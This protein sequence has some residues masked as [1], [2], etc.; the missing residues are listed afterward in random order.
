MRWKKLGKIFNPLEH[1]LADN[2]KEFAQSP[3]VL[4]LDTCYRVYFST[5]AIDESGKYISYV[6]FAEF[7]KSFSKVLKVSDKTIITRGELGTFDEHGIFP[8]N[9]LRDGD[10][11]LGYTSGWFRRESVLVDS[12]IGLTISCDNGLTFERVGIGPVLGP[13]LNEPFLIADPFVIKYQG[14]YHMW[15]VYGKTWIKGVNGRNPDRVYKIGHA[16]SRDRINWEQEG[17]QILPDFL[18]EVECQALPTI[19]F[20][21]DR[22]HMYFCYR[23]AT[24]FRSNPH[25]AY[26]L[27]YA[28]SFDLKDWIRNDEKAGIKRSEKGWDSEMMCYPFLFSDVNKNYLLYNGNAFGRYG[29]GLAVLEST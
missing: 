14:F 15:Y 21:E 10:E 16:I 22:W 11:L 12:A 9:I 25:R 17:R 4:V 5:R 3:Q 6:A 20:I 26:R 19:C 27:G 23:Y 13:S 24:D 2:C 28:Y 29:F 1:T 8:M 7:D 18:D